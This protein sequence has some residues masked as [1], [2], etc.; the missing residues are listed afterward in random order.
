MDKGASILADRGIVKISGAE[1]IDFL[2]RLVTNSL[3]DLKPG[4]AR[5][6]AFALRPGQAA[7]RFLRHAAPGR[8]ASGLPARLSARADSGPRQKLNLHKLRA[9]VTI[10][11]VSESLAVAAI[12]GIPV[13]ADFSGIAFADPRAEALGTRLIAPTRSARFRDDAPDLL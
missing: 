5:Y 13:P 12:W 11:D 4:E 10:E 8:P 3:L 1:T 6:A 9:P 2:H 7:L